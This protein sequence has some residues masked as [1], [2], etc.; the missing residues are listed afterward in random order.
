MAH[1]RR[2]ARIRDANAQPSTEPPKPAP[3]ETR[4]AKKRKASGDDQEPEKSTKGKKRVTRGK[5]DA[6]PTKAN[7]KTNAK[8]KNKTDSNKTLAPDDALSVLPPEILE[9]IME[10]VTD[11]PNLLKLART[12]R[13]YY[14]YV[15]PALH[16]R[17]A[18]KVDSLAYVPNVIRLIEP[19]LS[20]AQKKQLKKEGKYKGQQD[21]FS[22]TLR[23][24]DGTLVTSRKIL[25]S[26]LLNSISTLQS[27]D[28]RTDKWHC[29]FLANWQD[30]I[31][32]RNP[33]AL[34]QPHDFIALKS[35]TLWG[36]MFDG[37][38]AERIMPNLTRAF[39]FLALRELNLSQLDE[40][41]TT[42]FHYLEALF[43][44]AD[45]TEICLRSL[46]LQMKGNESR[47]AYSHIESQLECVYRFI[48]SF[49]T[50][51]S[52]QIDSYNRFH[53]AMRCPGLSTSL[54]Q[55]ILKHKDLERLRFYYEATSN[56]NSEIPYVSATTVALLTKS[57]PRLR[58]FEFP[59]QETDL[60]EMGRALS[61]AKNLTTLTCAPYASQ[62][63]GSQDDNSF[64]F[65]KTI[66]E[67]FL[68][69]T[70]STGEFVWE[71]N[72]KLTQL[73]MGWSLGF[74]IGSELKPGENLEEPVTISE[75][76]STVMCQRLT[77]KSKSE[78]NW[79]SDTEWVEN[80]AK[81]M[82]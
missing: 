3:T 14:A 18:V 52:L 30:Q 50:L 28:I 11:A 39:D 48:S 78:N 4:S 9:M 7:T 20:I 79:T 12:S 74:K 8:V 71:D 38:H 17:I 76:D 81:D 75:G 47:Q 25:Q 21:R 6:K 69:S 43:S 37:R 54:E 58:V 65:A 56:S 59:P 44:S 72:Y 73:V 33:D 5:A 23:R 27:L 15:M 57:L 66:I 10:N 40:S 82:L 77:H 1:P 49:D 70:R 32:A 2:S 41:K 51:T 62:Y 61:Q 26:I 63:D 55:A 46:S 16:K 67:G 68:T 29:D 45:K 13:R 22:D 24:Y 60:A 35:L 80:V 31:K 64:T 36:M 19:H 34:K 53:G 42:F